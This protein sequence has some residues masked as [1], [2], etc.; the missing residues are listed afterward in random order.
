MGVSDVGKSPETLDGKLLKVRENKLRRV[1]AKQGIKVVKMWQ[2]GTYLMFQG[3][4][5]IVPL[6][7][8]GAGMTLAEA[9]QLLADRQRQRPAD[10]SVVVAG[11]W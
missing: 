7:K 3:S 5:S 2:D 4:R 6:E 8:R 11:P 10:D 9:E 1:A